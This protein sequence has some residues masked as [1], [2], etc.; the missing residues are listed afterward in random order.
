MDTFSRMVIG[1]AMGD[2]AITDLI[3][4]SVSLAVHNRRPAG[5]VIHHSY[6]GSQHTSLALSQ[7]LVKSGLIGSMGTVGDALD[8]AVAESFFATLQTEPLDCQAWPT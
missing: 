1:R 6:H 8:N 3:L 2:R 7:Y 4:R 5:N